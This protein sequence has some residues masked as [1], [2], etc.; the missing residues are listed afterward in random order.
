GASD[1]VVTVGAQSFDVQLRAVLDTGGDLSAWLVVTR[2]AT[3]RQ[4]AS[5]QRR[6]LD[7]RLMDQ[8][9]V[10]SLSL[11]A[12]GLAHDFRS[13]LQGIMGN[14]E[15]VGLRSAAD[16]MLQESVA[17]IIIAPERASYLVSR[18]QDY[19]GQRPEQ[20]EDVDLSAV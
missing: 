5:A 13:L 16:P 10:E 6:A 18:M 1:E 17:A 11:L 20:A 8:Q 2:N 3:E 15:L 12:G 7:Q 19:A 9:R 4:K 14:A